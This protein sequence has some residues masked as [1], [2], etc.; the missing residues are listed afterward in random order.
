MNG[1]GPETGSLAR[2]PGTWPAAVVTVTA[3]AIISNLQAVPESEGVG[4]QPHPWQLLVPRVPRLPSMCMGTVQPKL[5]P[6]KV[7]A[8]LLLHPQPH[9]GVDSVGGACLFPSSSSRFGVRWR[10]E[11]AG[12]VTTLLSAA[13][14]SILGN[15]ALPPPRL[16]HTGARAGAA[17]GRG[18]RLWHGDLRV[19]PLLFPFSSGWARACRTTYNVTSLAEVT[20]PGAFAGA[21]FI[22]VI[23]HLPK[24]ARANPRVSKLTPHL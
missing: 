19:W 2:S 1:E 20:P 21:P 5:A 11:R 12:S 9:P 15:S 7:T 6:Y 13:A 8:P 18:F 23:H 17:L 4:T 14:V 16:A 10:G 24:E 3:I 22:A